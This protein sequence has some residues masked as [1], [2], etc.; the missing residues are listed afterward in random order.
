MNGKKITYV[1][2]SNVPGCTVGLF[3]GQDIKKHTVIAEFKDI[4]QRSD[5][6][7]PGISSNISIPSLPDIDIIG[8]LGC[9]PNDPINFPEQKRKIMQCLRSRIP[10]YKKHQNTVINGTI[11]VYEIARRAVLV[12]TRDIKKDS[13]ILCHYGFNHWFNKEWQDIG[14]L[15]EKE[16]I[17][18]NQT[19][20]EL[21]RYPG[22]IHYIREW[23]DWVER[24][25]AIPY[26]IDTI[27]LILHDKRGIA[28]LPVKYTITLS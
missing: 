23:Y 8:I 28:I 21:Y 4:K 1:K 10:F 17:A 13:E 14:F 20:T 27:G 11:K 5:E 12:A 25:E 26:S 16:L 2:K 3:A 7:L 9:C 19:I 18:M 15:P 6:T 22:F 24:I